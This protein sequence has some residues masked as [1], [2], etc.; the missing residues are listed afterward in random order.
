MKER[1]H[2][3]KIHRL[4]KKQTLLELEDEFSE[5]EIMQAI[6]AVVSLDIAS[7][8][9]QPTRYR[10]FTLGVLLAENDRLNRH[11]RQTEDIECANA[12]TSICP[13]PGT[14]HYYCAVGGKEAKQNCKQFKPYEGEKPYKPL[15]I[16]ISSSCRK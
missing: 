2:H 9:T 16:I 8:D 4:I 15:G 12:G 1:G 10:D 6:G 11:I 3:Y 13:R 7:Q 14:K 5:E